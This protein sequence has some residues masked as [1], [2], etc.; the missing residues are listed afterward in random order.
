MVRTLNTTN[1]AAVVWPDF[2]SGEGPQG[3]VV[4]GHKSLLCEPA[5]IAICNLQ[6]GIQEPEDPPSL[7]AV[8]WR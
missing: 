5:H 8:I 2:I 1:M 6:G 7:C 3:K 4:A